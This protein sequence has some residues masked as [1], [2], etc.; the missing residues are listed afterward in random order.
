MVME[1]RDRIIESDAQANCAS[2]RIRAR[3]HALGC[4]HRALGRA[5]DD[6]VINA[7]GDGA[8]RDASGRRC[9]RPSSTWALA[10]LY[11]PVTTWNFSGSSRRLCRECAAI[12]RS[13]RGVSW[14]AFD[15][16]WQ[17][18]DGLLPRQSQR[19]TEVYKDG[20]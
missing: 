3:R 6:P 19:P 11:E 18:N 15:R 7:S 4:D 9:G 1:R 8:C 5:R 12:M 14:W 17:G 16:R 10:A 2:G 13:V 20:V